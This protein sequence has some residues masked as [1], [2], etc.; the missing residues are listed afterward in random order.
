MKT[1]KFCKATRPKVVLVSSRDT[2][3]QQYDLLAPASGGAVRRGHSWDT[4]LTLRDERAILNRASETYYEQ[5]DYV[6]GDDGAIGTV[7][8]MA[9]IWRIYENH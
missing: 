4:I 1:I 5:Y 7:P 6:V 8:R 9:A 3:R 2:C